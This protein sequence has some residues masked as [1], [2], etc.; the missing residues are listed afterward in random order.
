MQGHRVTRYTR[1]MGGY[2]IRA[3]REDE[4]DEMV[5]I[6]DDAGALFA[7]AGIDFSAL[8]R[9]HPYLRHER[10]QW[11]AASARGEAFLAFD[12]AGDAAGLLVLDW[13]DDTPYLEQLSVRM[14]AMKRGLGRLLLTRAV[15]WAEQH[16]GAL[17]LTTYGHVAWNRPFYERAAFEVVPEAECGPEMRACL[18]AQRQA[19]P[20]PEHRIAMRRQ[21]CSTE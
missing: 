20:A 5:S 10:E 9:D 7:S 17:W 12:G 1:P 21:S 14:R 16:G 6:D 4:I 15:A 13:I 2:V 18:A 8:T 11:L 3:A 19:L